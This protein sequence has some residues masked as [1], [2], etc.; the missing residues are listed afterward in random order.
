MKLWKA[1]LGAVAAVAIS[2]GAM[3]QDGEP[4]YGGVLTLVVGSEAPSW[5]GH[6]ETTFG[7]IHPIAPFYSLLVRVNP[8][9]PGDPT[10]IQCDV[11]SDWEVSEDGK[12]WTFDIRSDIKFHDGT[13]LTAQDVLATFE[14]I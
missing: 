11:C 13:P 4:K 9:N 12:T 5:D 6:I 1:A 10:D 2:T 14:K 7:T 3:A 8:E